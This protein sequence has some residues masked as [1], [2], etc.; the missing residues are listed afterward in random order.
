MPDGPLIIQSDHTL[1]LEVDHAGY[2]DA[3][4]DLLGF[5][6]LVKSPEH[7]HTYRITPLS[8]WNARAAGHSADDMVTALEWHA[9]FPPPGNVIREL[10]EQAQ[11][12]GRL[13]LFKQVFADREA[14]VAEDLRLKVDTQELADQ[15]ASTK[16]LADH[17]NLRDDTDP[18][19]FVLDPVGRGVVKQALIK[20]GYPAE[21]YAGYTG[22]AALDLKLRDTTKQRP[23]QPFALRP[24]QQDAV[25]AFAGA[26]G[27]EGMGG[28]GVIVLPC[29]A[30]KTVIGIAAMAAAGTATLILAPSTTAVRQWIAELLDKT[31]LEAH[32]VAEYSGSTKDIAP[33]TVATY[34]VLTSRKNKDAPLEHLALFDREDWGLIVYDEAHLLPA[35]VFAATATIQ[36]R[37][38]LG[39]TATLVREDGREED[40][41]ALIG[42]K[43]ADVPWKTLEGQGWIAKARCVEVRVE[44]P[45]DRMREYHAADRRSMFRIAS[46]N[47]AKAAQV[48]R[49]LSL[50]PGEP[51]LV[52]GMYVDQLKELAAELDAPLIVGTTSQRKRDAL[53]EAFRKG[54]IPVLVVS[55][56]ANFAVDLPDASLAVQVSGTFGSRQEEAQRLGRLLRPKAPK[57]DA[58][59]DPEANQAHFYSLVS[60]DTN[61]Q[62]FALNRQLFL[63]EQGYQY[64]LVDAEQDDAVLRA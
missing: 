21:D 17:L 64:R 2:A 23:D 6:E 16:G 38:R 61:E 51:A 60:R 1:L 27:D 44:M 46:E 10:R 63:C 32:Q 22:G 53:F 35:P 62:D 36:S 50:H 19:V 52:I 49:I 5:A 24:Y 3:R 48:K 28:S 54:E 47:P 39:L 41:F 18:T 55:K 40:V 56:V 29:G 43:K 20:A 7:V 59:H 12:Y 58:G 42:P 13:R 11:R 15:L 25:N 26:G 30:G 45:D 37:R 14:G 31:T 57:G 8:V 4:N 9:R 33:V 34:Q